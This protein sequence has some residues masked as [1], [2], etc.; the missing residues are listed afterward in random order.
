MPPRHCAHSSKQ[1][2]A[3]LKRVALR[4]LSPGLPASLPPPG[5]RAAQLPVGEPSGRARDGVPDPPFTTLHTTGPSP[6]SFGT[7]GLINV[8]YRY[9]YRYDID[10]T[11]CCS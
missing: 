10:S 9:E 8:I 11:R 7:F 3:S 2:D 1:V 5:L 6:A 4:V